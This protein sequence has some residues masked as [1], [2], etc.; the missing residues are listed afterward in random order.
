MTPVPFWLGGSEMVQSSLVEH[1]FPKAGPPLPQVKG[2]ALWFI[3]PPSPLSSPSVCSVTAPASQAPKTRGDCAEGIHPQPW[4]RLYKPW[5]YPTVTYSSGTTIPI[6]WH[7]C[8]SCPNY[9]KTSENIFSRKW[10]LLML[11]PSLLWRTPSLQ[12]RHCTQKQFA[13]CSLVSKLAYEFISWVTPIKKKKK[14][15]TKSCESM[16]STFPTS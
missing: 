14:L 1:C 10:F 9:N 13:P 2:R 12:L 11:I 5:A 8:K 6:L 16:K 3:P 7:C 15:I 4:T